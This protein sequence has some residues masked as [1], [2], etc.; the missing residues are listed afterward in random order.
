MRRAIGIDEDKIESYLEM[1][2]EL[3]FKLEKDIINMLSDLYN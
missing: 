3:Q 1:D 2:G